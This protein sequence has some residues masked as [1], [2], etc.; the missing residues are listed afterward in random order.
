M[1]NAV[2]S[3]MLAR[4]S[5]RKF[6]S[7][8]PT[9]EVIQEIVRAGQQAP[10]AGQLCSVILSRKRKQPMGAPIMFTICFD[11]HRMELIMAKRGWKTVANDLSMMLF[12]IQDAA[13]MAENMVIAAESLVLGSCYLGNAPFV[14]KNLQKLYKLPQRVFPIVQLIMGYPAEEYPTRPRYPYDFSCFEETYPE[15]TDEMVTDA[16]KVMD[17]GYLAQGY[18][19]RQH[20]KIPLENQRKETFTYDNY[21]WTEHISRKWGQ[22]M[23]DPKEILAQFE[24]CGFKIGESR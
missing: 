20:A 21:S 19:K 4:K 18:Y 6:T 23:K 10:F 11:M 1:P 2:I 12:G 13:Y 24:K 3:T 8:K 15:L 17:D 16:M 7:Q 5:V 14:A 22:W 9:D